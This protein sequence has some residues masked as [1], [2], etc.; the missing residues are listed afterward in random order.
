[1]NSKQ[2]VDLPVI[3]QDDDSP[4]PGC[5]FCGGKGK[6]G[7]KFERVQDKFSQSFRVPLSHELCKKSI[8]SLSLSLS[9][10]NDVDGR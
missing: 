2:C 9:T 1:M 10:A 7:E 5:T 3:T 8:L 6:P 4:R